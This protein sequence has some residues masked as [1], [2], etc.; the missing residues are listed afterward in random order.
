MLPNDLL[1]T[2]QQSNDDSIFQK[3]P[4]W[5]STCHISIVGP[6]PSS[7]ATNGRM[8]EVTRPLHSAVEHEL[9]LPFRGDDE[10]ERFLLA[11]ITTLDVMF[12]YISDQA[13]TPLVI[14]ARLR[15]LGCKRTRCAHCSPSDIQEFLV[16]QMF[17]PSKGFSWGK[18]SV[19]S[20]VI[21]RS[22]CSFTQGL[23]MHKVVHPRCRPSW[24]H[25]QLESN[26]ARLNMTT[27]TSA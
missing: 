12:G 13:M 3:L 16:E 10:A 6:T 14:D 23:E 7:W 27:F 1:Q 5:L 9:L 26:R 11:Q 22:S 15:A 19:P 8:Y 18:Q 4:T 21:I 24:T 2:Y 25:S 20:L 17:P